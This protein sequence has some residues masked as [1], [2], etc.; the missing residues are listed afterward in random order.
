MK[1]YSFSVPK[2]GIPEPVKTLSGTFS[3]QGVDGRFSLQGDRINFTL[4]KRSLPA[5]VVPY[6]TIAKKICKLL[7][8][9]D[10]QE[11]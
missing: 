10:F 7:G 1:E 8:A 2:C 5:L 11:D 9:D 3:Q 6:K 4:Q